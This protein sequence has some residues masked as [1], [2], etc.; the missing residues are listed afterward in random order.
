[1]AV[2]PSA[3]ECLK[4]HKTELQPSL[5][6]TQ[7]M[8]GSPEVHVSFS[9]CGSRKKLQDQ[10][11]ERTKSMISHHSLSH[12]HLRGWFGF[13]FLFWLFLFFILSDEGFPFPWIFCPGPT[14][15]GWTIPG[16]CLGWTRKQES[17][18]LDGTG[19]FFWGLTSSDAVASL[20]KGLSLGWSWCLCAGK[21]LVWPC[22]PV[23]SFS[24]S[25]CVQMLG[26]YTGSRV[27]A[28]KKLSV[29]GG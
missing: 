11:R 2:F 18:G 1:M 29:S 4:P 20:R 24:H 16:W 26:I 8:M 9:H 5:L 13:F 3:A 6:V 15:S 28:N 19:I 21:P 12:L 23:W 22:F 10:S 7:Q 27:D 25:G 14:L 17:Q